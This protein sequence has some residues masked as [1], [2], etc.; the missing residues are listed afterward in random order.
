MQVLST[1]LTHVAVAASA[2][3][4]V[5][6][7]SIASASLPVYKAVSGVTGNIKSIGSD[8]MNNEMALWGEGFTKFYPTVKIEVEG[9][10]SSTAPAALIAG[11]AHF[12][13]MSR[14]MK[15]KEVADFEK[16]FGYKPTPVKT[17]LDVLAVYVHQ[18]NPIK[19]LNLQQVD[20]IF[21]KTR[22]GGF[23]KNVVKWKDLG[24]TELKGWECYGKD[25]QIYGRN[26]AS[27]T[28]GYFKKKALF[29]GDYKDSV[30]EQAGS[31]AVV[32]AVSNDKCAIG[33]SGIG[34]ITPGVKAVS[35]ASKPGKKFVEATGENATTGA[36][37]LARYLYLYVNKAPKKALEPLRLEF[38]RYVLS[39]KGQEAVEKVG[40]IPL[41]KSVLEKELK[42]IEN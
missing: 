21:S 8:T 26:S 24:L 14:A 32:Q 7:P 19:G 42:K 2:S 6:V 4:A 38:L 12:G 37:S 39:L 31:S 34:Y 11:Q 22:K 15:K 41:P 17:S 3:V 9:K 29:K 30:K 33:Y 27:G 36:Y 20:A 25:I 5:A 13:P 10:G 23:T 18:N 28:Y 1:K 35:L 16:K 40:Y